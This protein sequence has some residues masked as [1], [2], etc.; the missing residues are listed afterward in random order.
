[1]ARWPAGVAVKELAIRLNCGEVQTIQHGTCRIFQGEPMAFVAHGDGRVS[2]CGDVFV[3]QFYG[4]FNLEG[5]ELSFEKLKQCW[6]SAGTPAR[7]ALLADARR[8]EGCTPEAIHVLEEGV[9]WC[10]ENGLAAYAY[11]HANSFM[12][13]IVVS[14]VKREFG[15]APEQHFERV[16]EAWA[17]LAGQGFD[18]GDSAARNL[19]EMPRR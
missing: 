15:K 19:V 1:M 16:D 5:A 4:A 17:W 8:W 2:R 6:L 13:E 14:S 3:L 11:L 9:V 12:R 7:W 10:R 18:C